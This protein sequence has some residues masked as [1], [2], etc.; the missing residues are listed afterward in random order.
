MTPEQRFPIYI[1]SG[2]LFLLSAI[3]IWHSRRF[4]IVADADGLRWHNGFWTER[5]ATWAQVS[6]YYIRPVN[7]VPIVETAAGTLYL[8]T[9]YTNR[10]DLKRAIA[11]RATVARAR[12]WNVRGARRCDSFPRTFRY[13]FRDSFWVMVLP[14]AVYLLI[15][16]WAAVMGYRKIIEFA[17]LIGWRE[18]LPCV[19]GGAIGLALLAFVPVSMVL[20]FVTVWKTAHPN[21]YRDNGNRAVGRRRNRRN[22]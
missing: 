9:E 17:A 5:T 12:E 1:I 20:H 11:E 22:Y 16:A 4:R 18:T 8:A 3:G 19:I 15:F 6:D 7:R 21:Y 2:L 14:V 13:Y 10:D